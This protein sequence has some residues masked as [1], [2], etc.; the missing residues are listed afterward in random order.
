MKAM[1]LP[2]EIQSFLEVAETAKE[3]TL[4]FT[5]E[6]RPVAALVSLIRVDRESLALST[7]PQ[8]LKIIER[9]RKEVHAGKT[10]SLEVLKRKFGVTAPNKRMA[11]PRKT[12]RSS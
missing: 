9:A 12:R 2:K 8:F 7:N 11:R 1:K 4:V 10:T 5:K 3:E 6:K